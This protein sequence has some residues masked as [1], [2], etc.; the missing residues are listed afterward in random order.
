MEAINA[1]RPMSDA[2]ALDE[3]AAMM[4]GQDW[5]SD[6][7]EQIAWLVGLTGRDIADT[8]EH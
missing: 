6:T 8:Q 2:D 7:G 3:I 5:D 1:E 4:S